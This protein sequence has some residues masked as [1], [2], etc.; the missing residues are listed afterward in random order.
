MTARER[1]EARARD[2][3]QA[4]KGIDIPSCPGILAQ[5]MDELRQPQVSG[6][7]IAALIGQD[8][9]LAA[10]VVRSAN[11][12][13][14]G[15]GRRIASI[16]DAI[17]ML[18]FGMLANLVQEA[19]LR[20]NIADPGAALERF[21]DSSRCTAQ[22]SAMLAR[23][24]GIARPETAYTFGL[25]H[26]CG[27][28]LLVKRFP[29][30]KRILGTANQATGRWFTDVEDEA[31]DTNH[32][33]IGYLLARSWGLTDAVCTGILCHHDYSVFS[34][35]S[36]LEVEAQTLIALNLVAEYVAGTHLRTRRDAEWDKG[37]EAVA[38]FL[39][40]AP[41]ELD[42]LADDL[43]YALDR[44]GEDLPA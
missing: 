14:F 20:S 25:F 5:L 16:D 32:A 41:T 18:G 38:R 35:D 15:S 21:W 39:G 29:D 26:D 31:L 2:S 40:Y 28:P 23:R 9:G 33:T 42:D 37:R 10:V 30:Y 34:P 11:S 8:V 22:A 1:R 36:G 3:K 17:R 19:L 7:R 12:P 27:I 6:K 13:Y 43:L 44:Q 24:T 4:H